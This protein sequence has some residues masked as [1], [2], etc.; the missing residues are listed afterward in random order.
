MCKGKNKPKD[1]QQ[2]QQ[3]SAKYVRQEEQEETSD[4]DV[5]F[6]HRADKLNTLH[7]ATV[8]VRFNGVKGTTEEDP[9]STANIMNEH[10]FEKLPSALE[11]K[12]TLPPTDTQFYAFAEKEPVPL[13][14]YFDAEIEGVNTGKKTTTRF[15]VAKGITKS[16]PLL[17]VD[18]SVKL[19]LLHVTNA[20]QEK[21]N[22]PA[23]SHTG[24]SPTGPVVSNLMLEY[25]N[26][27][28]GLGKHKHIKAKLIVDESIQPV[29]HKQRRIPYNLAQKAAQEE[30]RLREQG[31]IEAV[32]NNQPTTWCT[33]PV[34]ASKPHNPEAIRFCSDMRV[35]DTAILR[36]VTE[37][38]T[39]EDINSNSRVPLSSVF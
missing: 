11:K 3:S 18:T 36:P 25:H 38:L 35:P 15:L 32:P 31:V 8:Q 19:G 20:S 4:S 27:F 9:C 33:N 12:I 16:P 26:I 14:G 10:K 34:I 6:Q 21:A 29:S 22:R 39:V 7:H 23:E 28:S 24:T 30:L 5:S 13:I 1:P 17:S 2:N 37:A